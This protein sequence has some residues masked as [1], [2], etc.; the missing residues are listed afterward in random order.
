MASISNDPN[1]RRRILFI[2]GKGERKAAR[3][4]KVPLRYAEA[5][6]VKI[7]DLVHAVTT[8]H[9][10]S[11]ETSRWLAKLDADLY[12]KLANAGLVKR[13]EA[14]TLG[15]FIDA[16]IARRSDV[17]PGTRRVY[18]RVCGYLVGFFGEDKPIRDITPGDADAWR[19]VAEAARRCRGAKAFELARS[20][21][22]RPVPAVRIREGNL[23]DKQ[24]VGVWIQAR[25][26]PWE[27]SGSWAATGFLRWVTSEDP[28]AAALRRRSEIVV[29]PVFN[30]DGVQDG[31][32][33]TGTKAEPPPGDPCDSPRYEPDL[34]RGWGHRQWG[35]YHLQ[36]TAARKALHD[37]H[38][39]TA[40]LALYI[41]MHNRA[42]RGDPAMAFWYRRLPDEQTEGGLQA[43]RQA[44]TEAIAAR[45]PRPFGLKMTDFGVLKVKNDWDWSSA[46]VQTRFPSAMSFTLEFVSEQ[47]KVTPKDAPGEMI[48]WGAAIAQGLADH[49]S[50]PS[51]P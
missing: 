11:D 22:D 19:E 7:E 16:Y 24:R 20:R 44:L 37:L 15:G 33:M 31:A 12:D 47:D 30:A 40:G 38:K 13:R 21:R 42:F 14:A 41:D 3:L 8:G 39:R 23:P 50:P 28:R 5:V 35:D 10:P 45:L 26:H 29:V 34:N 1:G 49:V 36:V 6:K 2:D 17:K 32:T 51:D 18:E 46:Y 43:R 25:A 48:A 4:G 9:A 27:L